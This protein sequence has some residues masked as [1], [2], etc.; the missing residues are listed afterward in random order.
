MAG[1]HETQNQRGETTQEREFQCSS[2]PLE[3][4]AEYS[5][6]YGLEKIAQVWGKNQF[7]RAGGTI[8]KALTR[9]EIVH[10]PTSQCENL[11]IPGH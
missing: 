11:I 10:C 1:A 9:P 6:E 7:K 2:E 8:R 4:S 3:P 5:P